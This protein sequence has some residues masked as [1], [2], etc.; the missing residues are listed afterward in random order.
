MSHRITSW[1]SK[2]TSARVIAL[3]EPLILRQSPTSGAEHSEARAVGAL[4][5]PRALL[6]AGACALPGCFAGL[7]AGAAACAAGMVVI[8]PAAATVR[9][10][11]TATPPRRPRES[12][13]GCTCELLACG[14]Q[15]YDAQPAPLRDPLGFAPA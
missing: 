3:V 10:S 11:A 1:Q 5:S 9:A 12:L 4:L 6:R 8:T 14:G 13:G 7:A 2:S 15:S